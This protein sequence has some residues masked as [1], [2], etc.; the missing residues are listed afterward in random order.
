MD[1]DEFLLAG[2]TMPAAT[3]TPSAQVLKLYHLS[4]RTGANG[5]SAKA[6]LF[7]EES[8]SYLIMRS[9]FIEVLNSCECPHTHTAQPP[10]VLTPFSDLCQA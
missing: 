7:N 9:D 5:R 6:V 1:A 10:T 4:Y 3:D 8:Q 2:G